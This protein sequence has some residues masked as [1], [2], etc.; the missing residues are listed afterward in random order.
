MSRAIVS[1]AVGNPYENYRGRWLSTMKQ[2]GHADYVRVFNDWPPD[3]PAHLEHH[4]AFKYFAMKHAADLGYT[5]ILWLDSAVFAVAPIDPVWTA[6]DRDGHVFVVDTAPLS[7]WASDRCLAHFD[8]TRDE[9]MD[10]KLFSGTWIGLD[11]DVPRSRSFFDEWGALAAE[12]GGLFMSSHFLTAPGSMRSLPI[13]DGSGELIS[14]DPR[15]LG[16]RSDEACFAPMAKKRG[17][18]IVDPEGLFNG[19]SGVLRTTPVEAV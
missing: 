10:L 8:M 13:A 1:V 3:S 16:H 18:V 4:Y 9:A 17:M 2:F 14:T 15:V 5:K 12:K 19:K 11:L 6:L 7:A